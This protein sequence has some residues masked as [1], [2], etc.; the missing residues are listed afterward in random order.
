MLNEVDKLAGVSA[1]SVTRTV[2]LEVPT[3]IGV[4]VMAPLPELKLSPC[5]SWPVVT[6]HVYG[7]IP[8]LAESEAAYGAAV[9]PAG[10]DEGE[11]E[12]GCGCWIA[13]ANC[14]CWTWLVGSVESVTCTVNGKGV[15]LAAVG[16]PVICPVE[17]FRASSL[18]RAPLTKAQVNGVTPPVVEI[19][20]LYG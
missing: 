13:I 20:V 18:G 5:G 16:T 9:L 4:P 6:L 15:E 3:R 7:G 11:I 8:P 19:N 2:K 1:E 14:F 17:V 12:R 10:K